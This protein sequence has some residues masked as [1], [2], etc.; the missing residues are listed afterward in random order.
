VHL[1]RRLSIRVMAVQLKLDK[2]TVK[3]AW[4]LAQPTTGFSTMTM[5]QLTRRCQAVSG[6]KI[7]YW[8]GILILFPCF[9]S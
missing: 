7:D 3:K 5:L 6:Q 1:D 9:G 2:E 8:N 4:T